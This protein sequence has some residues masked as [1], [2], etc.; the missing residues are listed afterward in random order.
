[1]T[2]GDPAQGGERT[3]SCATELVCHRCGVKIG[4]GEREAFCPECGKPVQQG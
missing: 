2:A 4:L 3:R 1:M